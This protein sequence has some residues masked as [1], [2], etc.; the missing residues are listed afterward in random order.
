MMKLLK[1]SSYWL[2]QFYNYFHPLIHSYVPLVTIVTKLVASYNDIGVYFNVC[3][4]IIYMH[5]YIYYS[6]NETQN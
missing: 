6:Y 3:T 5:M 4:K 2:G 1:I